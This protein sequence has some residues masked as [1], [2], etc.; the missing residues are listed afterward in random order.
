MKNTD[1]KKF[2]KN[3]VS[4]KFRAELVKDV[5][6][7]ALNNSKHIWVFKVKRMEKGIP[8]VVVTFKSELSLEKLKE[9]MIK[10]E[11]AHVMYQ[12]LK[13]KEEYDGERMS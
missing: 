5:Y 13:I 8:D 4:Y 9:K 6:D 10:I 2:P 3:L 1:V 7:F 11:D 12:S